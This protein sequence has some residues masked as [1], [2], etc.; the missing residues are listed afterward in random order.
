M[1]KISCGL[2]LWRAYLI[3]HLEIP[4]S[5]QGG[6]LGAALLAMNKPETAKRFYK[7]GEIVKP[8]KAL[9]EYYN[10]KYKD[11]TDIQNKIL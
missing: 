1:P 9:A 4:D 5:E 8:D 11:F 6:A 7:T 10:K 2:K 3:L